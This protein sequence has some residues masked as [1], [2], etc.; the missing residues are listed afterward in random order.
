LY[1]FTNNN[2]GESFWAQR[3]ALHGQVKMRSIQIIEVQKAIKNGAKYIL[4]DF[5]FNKK[6]LKQEDRLT[7]EI[8][9]LVK[10]ANRNVH[11]FVLSSVHFEE[12]LLP[13]D[14]GTTQIFL[15]NYTEDFLSV[16]AK[17]GSEIKS[18]NQLQ[19]S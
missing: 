6:S 5:Y 4:V 14:E 13:Y 11:L 8:N 12:P 7:N 19:L 1:V 16:L 18:R 10:Q 3:T 9:T 2:L 15:Q 17:A